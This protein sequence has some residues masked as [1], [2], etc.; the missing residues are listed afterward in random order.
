M[1]K[2]SSVELAGTLLE[3]NW[4]GKTTKGK[5]L[6]WA[7][8]LPWQGLAVELIDISVV[9]VDGQSILVNNHVINWASDRPTR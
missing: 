1:E 4:A 8:K 9:P 6:T 5:N 2:N 3:I 7:N